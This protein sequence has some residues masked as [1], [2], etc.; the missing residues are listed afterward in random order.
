MKT[1]NS[2]MAAAFSKYVLATMPESLSCSRSRPSRNSMH[3][4]VVK[5]VEEELRR[6]ISYLD[7]SCLMREAVLAFLMSALRFI[8]GVGG[9][10]CKRGIMWVKWNG[11]RGW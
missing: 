1:L 7:M 9:G 5:L 11:G 2:E 6:A 4:S 10:V 8:G 3:C